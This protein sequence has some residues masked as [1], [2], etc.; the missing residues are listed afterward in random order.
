[1]IIDS[2]DP[3]Q[4]LHRPDVGKEPR[5]NPLFIALDLYYGEPYLAEQIVYL[6]KKS[7]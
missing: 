6:K 5:K 4:V 2:D 1:M 7:L 3:E